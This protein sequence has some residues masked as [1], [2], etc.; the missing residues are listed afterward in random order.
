MKYSRKKVPTA[1]FYED[2]HLKGTYLLFITKVFC[3]RLFEEY[4]LAI[5]FVAQGMFL[6]VVFHVYCVLSVWKFMTWNLN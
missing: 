4:E 2:I 6:L 1:F 5:G 3:P